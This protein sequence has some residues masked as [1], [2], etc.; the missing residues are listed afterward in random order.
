[1]YASSGDAAASCGVTVASAIASTITSPAPAS[2]FS[3]VAWPASTLLGTSLDVSQ[4]AIVIATLADVPTTATASAAGIR[5]RRRVLMIAICHA[6]RSVAAV[7]RDC[8]A[9]LRKTSYAR[10]LSPCALFTR[11]HEQRCRCDPTGSP[12]RYQRTGVSGRAS[13]TP[14][15]MRGGVSS[16]QP[17]NAVAV[18]TAA[19]EIA[20]TTGTTRRRT[21]LRFALTHRRYHGGCDSSCA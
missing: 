13:G 3:E 5:R 1:M 4:P 6:P 21:A 16:V 19:V 12:N 20:R 15:S 10:A 11:A 17:D 18:V 8:T 14:A 9:C 7:R 2:S